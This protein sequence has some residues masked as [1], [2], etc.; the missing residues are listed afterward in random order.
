VG[1]EIFAILV[2]C[3]ENGAMQTHSYYGSLTGS[4]YRVTSYNFE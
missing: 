4:H 2:A 3:L 1:Y